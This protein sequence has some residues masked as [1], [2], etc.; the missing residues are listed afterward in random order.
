MFDLRPASVDLLAAA[1]RTVAEWNPHEPSEMARAEVILA[2]RAA[3]VALRELCSAPAAAQTTAR[4]IVELYHEIGRE[5]GG[6]IGG[7]IG[8]DVTQQ[9]LAPSVLWTR[10]AK[11]IRAGQFDNE[12]DAPAVHA[13]LAAA[14]RRWLQIANPNYLGQRTDHASTSSKASR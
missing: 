2:G 1:A 8:G 7:A 13:L 3:A 4:E 11:D 6:A 14:A 9:E 5:I 10:L 12:S